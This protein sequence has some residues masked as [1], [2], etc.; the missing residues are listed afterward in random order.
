[1][2]IKG[3]LIAAFSVVGIGGALAQGVEYDDMYFNSEDRVKLNAQRGDVAYNTPSKAKKFDYNESE[4]L[5]PTDSYSARNVNPEYTSRA[6]TQTAQ[7]DE[8][9]YFVNNYQYNRSH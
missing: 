8:E 1:M 3:F 4:S 7:Q 6:H 5:N 9:D 2:K